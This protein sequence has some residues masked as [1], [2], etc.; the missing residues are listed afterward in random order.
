METPERRGAGKVSRGA[1]GDHSDA[2]STGPGPRRPR[3]GTGTGT[4]QGLVF[5]GH[6][7]M[8]WTRQSCV[9][10]AQRSPRPGACVGSGRHDVVSLD[11]ATLRSP[12][13]R[14]KRRQV[15]ARVRRNSAF[16]IRH[17]ETWK[18]W[19]TGLDQQR[20]RPAFGATRSRQG[21]E[22]TWPKTQRH[23][24]AKVKAR[25]GQEWGSR[26]WAEG[27]VGGSHPASLDGEPAERKAR[28]SRPGGAGSVQ[29]TRPTGN[30]G[31]G[32]VCLRGGSRPSSCLP[33][34]QPG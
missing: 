33:S 19:D 9:K 21:S 23:G 5:R 17:R 11:L 27:R 12:E 28:P 13:A 34:F 26:T 20:A 4:R 30:G 24:A 1:S 31:L 3:M 25:S 7:W 32:P 16:R 10:G 18:R 22:E 2:C 8:V 15:F 29:L 6:G 14:E